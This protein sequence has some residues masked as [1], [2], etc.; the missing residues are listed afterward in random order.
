[1]DRSGVLIKVQTELFET[2]NAAENVANKFRRTGVKAFVV[3]TSRAV[4]G[5]LQ[6]EITKPYKDYEA[7][8]YEVIYGRWGNGRTRRE[9]LESAGYSYKMIQDRV[10]DILSH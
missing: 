5:S 3:W 2:R 1:M 4:S 8:I 7:I 9:R 6:D 10:N